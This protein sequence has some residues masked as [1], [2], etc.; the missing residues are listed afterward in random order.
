[1]NSSVKIKSII[2]PA[3]LSFLLFI[4]AWIFSVINNIEP[5]YKK[6]KSEFQNA[7]LSQ[8]KI[9]SDKTLE[10]ANSINSQEDLNKFVFNFNYKE[11]KNKNLAFYI[12][13][14]DNLLFWSD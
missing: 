5:D 9:I 13:E 6:I 4:F 3:I 10:I 7:F 14:D 8:E 2:F 11:A 12:Y 1:M